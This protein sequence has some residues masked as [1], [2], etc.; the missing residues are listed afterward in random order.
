MLRK[1]LLVAVAAGASLVGYGMFAGLGHTQENA[2]KPAPYV[3]VVS[4]YRKTAAPKG[5]AEGRSAAP[6]A[7]L[8]KIPAG[9]ALRAGRPADMDTPMFAKKDYQVGLLVLFDNYD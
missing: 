5:A 8:R 7:L 9:R 4:C 3:H 1:L 6:P 2:A